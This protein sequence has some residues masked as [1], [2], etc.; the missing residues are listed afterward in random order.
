MPRILK[1]PPNIRPAIDDDVPA[2]WLPVG[3]PTAVIDVIEVQY[4]VLV[5]APA[6][7]PV[8]DSVAALPS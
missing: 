7:A 2:L 6:F 8:I 3:V 4:P 1:S 5:T